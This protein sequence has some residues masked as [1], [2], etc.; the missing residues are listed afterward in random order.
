MKITFGKYIQRDSFIH[1]FDGRLKF[2]TFLVFLTLIFLKNDFLPYFIFL[3]LF[4]LIFV[5]AKLPKIILWYA[6]QPVLF[7]IVFLFLFNI[8]DLEGDSRFGETDVI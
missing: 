1:H 4:L 6:F 7:M 5:I 8:L 3:G 2:V